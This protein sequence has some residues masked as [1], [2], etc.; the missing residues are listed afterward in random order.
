MFS[1]KRKV[2]LVGL[3]IFLSFSVAL[4]LAEFSLKKI[5]KYQRK[6]QPQK[7]LDYGDT[8]RP[9]GL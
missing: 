2:W 3:T 6:Y 1:M 8:V 4:V 7:L 5:E 9:E